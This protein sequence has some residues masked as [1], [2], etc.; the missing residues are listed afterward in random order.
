MPYEA[1]DN[2]GNLFKNEKK[3]N[4]EKAPDYKGDATID[5]VSYW[6]SAWIKTSPKTGQKFMS[7]SY[8]PKESQ[9][10]G[11][12]SSRSAPSQRHNDEVPF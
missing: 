9:G 1:R 10:G 11:K 3:G 5:G 12:P 4:N 6:V 8:E 2:T 7:L